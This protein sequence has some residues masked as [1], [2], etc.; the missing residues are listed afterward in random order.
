[1]TKKN[2]YW[3]ERFDQIEQVANN[4]S[5][6]YA[7]KLEKKYKT[8]ASE[9]DA[10]INKWYNRIA[11][12]NEIS[13]SEARRL[14]SASELK[15]FKWTVEEYIARGRE[16]A[17]NQQ[18]MKELENA[19]AKFH[20]NRL[21]A[22]K[23]ECRHQIEMAMANGQQDMFDV[24]SDVYKDTFYRANYEIQ[25]SIGIGFDVA[26]LDDN[27]VSSVINKPWA[28]DGVNFSDRIWRNKTKLLNTLDEEITRMVLTG[29]T[30]KKAITAV[31]DAMNSSL[32]QAKRLVVTE[33]AYFTSEAQKKC[34][35]SLDVEEFE[36]ISSA[37]LKV[38][39][40]C[41]ANDAKHH[42]MKEFHIGITAPPFHPLCRCVTAPFF[43]DE[44]TSPTRWV[45]GIDG[46]K[47]EI[48]ANM[49]YGEWKNTFVEGGSKKKYKKSDKTET[50]TTESK[51]LAVQV[52]ET[53]PSI[54]NA[55]EIATKALEGQYTHRIEDLGLDYLPLEE[56]TKHTVVKADFEGM[57]AR[58]AETSAEQFAELSSEYE[59]TCFKISVDKFDAMMGS[60]PAST[61][62]QMHLSQAKIS[63]NKSVVKDYDKFMERM[64][65][66]VERGQFPKMS[67]DVYE[68]YVM[69]HEFAH[70]M[71]DFDSPLK[72]Y[73]N[74]E[75]KHIKAARKEIRAIRDDYNEK[76]RVLRVQQREAELE[77]INTFDE[78]AWKKAQDIAAELKK[79]QISNYADMSVDEF[80]A[81][82][83]TDAK[84]GSEPT[85]HSK[86]V[87]AVI[88]KYFGKS[89]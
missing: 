64:N 51:P 16:N 53:K 30:P 62:V 9:I 47:Y 67:A 86:Q 78:S 46:E 87:L 54:E 52:E 17:V 50:Q 88:D 13:M 57:D 66:A 58:L 68:K 40:V 85:E 80:M 15:E 89:K 1:M 56:E 4:K 61:D 65:S 2:S 33:Q 3:Q 75:T 26:K 6:A 77:A 24:L 60:V 34:F 71:L 73:V 19:S 82:A 48:P 32:F 41:A 27:L 10:Q 29:D 21:E 81:E 72:N 44:F 28:A 69:T 25:R 14:L 5:T 83:F 84:I 49:N 37:D 38:C 22:M 42:P 23:L 11:K 59:N 39:P 36:V 79:T 7:K 43:N 12:N 18:W 63:F 74:A 20:I 76:L 45:T 31:K 55:N 70:T 35:N 8:A